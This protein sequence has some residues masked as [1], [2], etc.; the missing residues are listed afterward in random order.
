MRQQQSRVANSPENNR[1]TRAAAI[2]SIAVARYDNLQH[3]LILLVIKIYPMSINRSIP[4]SH[5]DVDWK[6]EHIQ[7]DKKPCKIHTPGCGH[8]GE[9]TQY[10]RMRHSQRRWYRDLPEER[11]LSRSRRGKEVLTKEQSEKYRLTREKKIMEMKK[12]GES[13]TKKQ[14]REQG[15]D[16][17]KELRQRKRKGDQVRGYEKISDYCQNP[18]KIKKIWRMNDNDDQNKA[19]PQS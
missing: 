7:H 1:S 15:Q 4:L 6:E 5:K 17:W 13:T 12:N 16:Y 18:T 14:N 11:K 9:L 3:L 10:E 19:S 8:W 2:Y